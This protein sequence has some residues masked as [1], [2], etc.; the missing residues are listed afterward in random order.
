M[1]AGQPFA[2]PAIPSK[3]QPT[4]ASLFTRFVRYLPA[5]ALSLLCLAPPRRA[6]YCSSCCRPRASR[7]HSATRTILGA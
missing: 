7:R 1:I 5:L 2:P 3:Q 6:S 4:T